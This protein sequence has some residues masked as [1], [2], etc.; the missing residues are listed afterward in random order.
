MLGIIFTTMLLTTLR[1]LFFLRLWIKSDA[2]CLCRR[3]AR[4]GFADIRQPRGGRLERAKSAHSGI[5]S[6][7]MLT[8][9]AT[10]GQRRRVTAVSQLARIEITS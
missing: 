7:L 10:T 4:G 5:P 8:P 1:L 9:R 3:S 2:W 6:V